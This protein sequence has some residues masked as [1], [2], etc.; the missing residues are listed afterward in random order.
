MTA[1]PLWGENKKFRHNNK[2]YK[3]KKWSYM[4][5]RTLSPT[6]IWSRFSSLQLTCDQFD[7]LI[8]S[9]SMLLADTNPFLGAS[10]HFTL[11]TCHARPSKQSSASAS[12]QI[13]SGYH[14]PH[15]RGDFTRCKKITSSLILPTFLLSGWIENRLLGP[16]KEVK[17]WW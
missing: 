8:L 9:I 17:C 6:R 7:L 16:K 14:N 4:A 2:Y 11:T 10:W 1:S 3:M 13:D 15:P 12:R 5:I